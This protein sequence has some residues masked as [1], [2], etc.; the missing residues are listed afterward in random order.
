MSV[1]HIDKA[2]VHREVIN[3]DKPVLLDFW[4][5]CDLRFRKV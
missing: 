3:S 1:I 4:P 2:N 5:C